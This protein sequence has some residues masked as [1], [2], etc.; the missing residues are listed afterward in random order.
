MER[1]PC[2]GCRLSN[3]RVQ[4]VEGTCETYACADRH[5]VNFCF[6]CPEFLCA[7]LN[8]AADKAGDLPHNIKLFVLFYIK[9]HGVEEWKK[10]TAEVKQ[11]YFGGKMIIGKGPQMG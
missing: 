6:D 4:F 11:R 7:K 3:G 8:P 1:R 5:G 2:P 9:Q 10:K